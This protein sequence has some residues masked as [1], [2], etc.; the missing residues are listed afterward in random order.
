MLDAKRLL[1]DAICVAVLAGAMVWGATAIAA[2]PATLPGSPAAAAGAAADCDKPAAPPVQTTVAGG[3]PGLSLADCG[4]KEKAGAD[5][6]GADKA[7]GER[8][9]TGEAG[10]PKPAATPDRP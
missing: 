6:A 8:A 10:G 4:D 2:V 7:G 9:G 1:I 5:K 3:L